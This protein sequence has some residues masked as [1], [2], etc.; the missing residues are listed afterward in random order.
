MPPPLG[1][2]REL[3]EPSFTLLEE[4]APSRGDDLRQRPAG[5]TEIDNVNLFDAENR[6]D[7]ARQIEE[8]DAHL[9]PHRDVHVTLDVRLA[10]GHRPEEGGEF[11]F[12]L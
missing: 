11:D 8:V 9:R 3:R 12:P 5:T 2:R 7:L 4:D 1:K 10:R 6:D